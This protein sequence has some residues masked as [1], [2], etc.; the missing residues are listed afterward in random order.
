MQM[1]SYQH[2]QI[3][4]T[5]MMSCLALLLLL[6][7]GSS[8]TSGTATPDVSNFANHKPVAI[9]KKPTIPLSHFLV[10]PLAIQGPKMDYYYKYP[11]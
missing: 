10:G 2:L 8:C 9:L 4:L 11:V 1:Q 7:M 5:A 3:N 6:P